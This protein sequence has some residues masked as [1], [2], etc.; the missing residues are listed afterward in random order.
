MSRRLTVIELYNFKITALFLE[1]WGFYTV[2]FF[3]VNCTHRTTYLF[4]ACSVLVLNS[5]FL[6]CNLPNKNLIKFYFILNFRINPLIPCKEDCQ[7][8]RILSVPSNFTKDKT[9]FAN[10]VLALLNN[11][12]SCKTSTIASLIVPPKTANELISNLSK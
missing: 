8:D 9:A 7:F 6:S 11:G 1:K 5:L 12:I 10:N 2:C 3:D 4:A